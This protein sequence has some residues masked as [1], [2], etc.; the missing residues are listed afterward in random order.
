S[1]PR[2]GLEPT[3]NRLTAGCSTIELSGIASH[4]RRAAGATVSF[5][6]RSRR[7]FKANRHRSATGRLPQRTAGWAPTRLPRPPPRCQSCA[8]TVATPPGGFPMRL[9]T[10]ETP[11]GPRAAVQRGVHYID[12]YA[13]DTALPKSVRHLLELGPAALKAAGHVADRET[14][15]RYE[16]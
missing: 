15:I 1:A 9:A 3:T 4:R 16:A 10:I 12:L 13:S 14:A 5:I 6:G 7:C 11:L 8:I 2:V